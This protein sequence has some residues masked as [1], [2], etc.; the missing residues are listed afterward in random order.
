MKVGEKSILRCRSEYAYGRTGSPPIIPADATLDFDVELLG[1]GPKK[2]ERWEM[3]PE[4]ILSDSIMLK[5]R[6]TSAFKEKMFEEA[7]SLY[8]EAVEL[9]S[10]K[11]DNDY[12]TPEAKAV[13]TACKLN[14]SQVHLINISQFLSRKVHFCCVFDLKIYFIFSY[15]QY[16]DCI[17]RRASTCRIT[18]VLLVQ[19]QVF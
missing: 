7:L 16:L 12:M 13:W 10:Q 1:F 17:S 14:S 9:L 2:K 4:E 18:P 5:D 19:H 11:D 6:G 15:N 3:S 8:E